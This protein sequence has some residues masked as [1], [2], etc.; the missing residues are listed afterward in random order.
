[1]AKRVVVGV[2]GVV[3]G[4]AVGM[5]F[6]MSL[7]LASTLIYPLPEGV[8]FTGQDPENVARM[9][10]WFG[11]L[12]AGAFLVA[13]ICHGLGCVVGAIVAMFVSGRRSLVPA[14]IIGVVFTACGAMNLSSLPHPAWFPFIDL[15]VYLVFALVAGLLLKRKGAEETQATTPEA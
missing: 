8:T 10:E 5:G 7:H 13:T 14:V 3:L 6:M 15:P 9:K 11:T 1:M 2:I 4:I 12:P